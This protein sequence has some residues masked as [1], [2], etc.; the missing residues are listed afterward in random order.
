MA[1]LVRTRSKPARDGTTATSSRRPLPHSGWAS[2]ANSRRMVSNSP[3]TSIA[4]I[5]S[6]A[7]LAP[8]V[9]GHAVQRRVDELGL[10]VVEEGLGQLDILVDDDLARHVLAL[11]QLPGPGAQQGAKGRVE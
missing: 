4:G 2:G 1:S 5:G 8:S 6:A 11:A 7:P 9:P 10:G 3:A